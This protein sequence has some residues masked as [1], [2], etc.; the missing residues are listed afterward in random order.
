[1][2]HALIHGRPRPTAPFEK[3]VVPYGGGHVILHELLESRGG[4]RGEER[5]LVR[6]TVDEPDLVQQ[7]LV[8]VQRRAGEEWI[9]RLASFG[10]PVVTPAVRGAVHAV[11]DWLERTAGVR[12]DARNY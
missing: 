9:V 1:M 4:D 3:Q 11:T 12:V 10:D 6:V 5:L 2:P 8:V 7:L